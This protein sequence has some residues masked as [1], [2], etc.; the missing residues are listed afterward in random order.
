M[1][2]RGWTAFAV[3]QLVG[4]VCVWS[5]PRILTATGPVL[6]LSGLAGGALDRNH[7]KLK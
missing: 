4:A 6:F 2:R 5:G 7:P 3:V 1:S